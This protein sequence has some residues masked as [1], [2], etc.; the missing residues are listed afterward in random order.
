MFITEIFNSINFDL[1][2]TLLVKTEFL[3]IL[4]LLSFI[5]NLILS[6]NKN[7]DEKSVLLMDFF[8]IITLNIFLNPLLAFTIYFC[9]LHSFRHSFASHLE[10]IGATRWDTKCLLGHKAND[11]TAQYVKVNVDRLSK[12]INQLSIVTF[13]SHFIDAYPRLL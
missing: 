8:S 4:L 2:N 10:E 11:V 9:F 5:S 12:Y 7:Y 1:S 13:L 6:F 3:V